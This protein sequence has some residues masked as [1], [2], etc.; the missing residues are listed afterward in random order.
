MDLLQR[1]IANN[2]KQ[3]LFAQQDR[4]VVAVS[5]GV[6]SVVLCELC[7]L[8]GLDFAMAHCNFQLRGEESQ[9]DETFVRGLEKRYQRTVW[10]K[11][12]DTEAYAT[13]NKLSIQEAARE[14]RYQ[15]FGELVHSTDLHTAFRHQQQGGGLHLLTAHHAGDNNETLLMHFFRGTGLH[16]LTGIPA[17]NGYVKRPLLGFTREEIREFA[18]EQ[19]LSWV[20][21][22][23]NAASDYTRNYFR[24]EL[25]PAISKVY[26]GVHQNLQDNIHR[27]SETEKLYRML[28]QGLLKKICVQK[29]N[30]MHVPVKALLKYD[31]RALIYELISPYGFHE[32]QVEEVLKLAGSESGKYILAPG[33]EW[34]IIKHRLWFIISPVLP[35]ASEA[36]IIEKDTNEVIFAGGALQLKEITDT[37]SISKDPHTALLDARHIEYPLLLRRWKTGDYFYPLGMRKKKK[38]GRFLIDL[39]LSKTEKENTWVIESKGRIIWVVGQRIDDR[40]KITDNTEQSVSIM[41]VC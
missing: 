9:R 28:V 12:F 22:S 40:C 27:F 13:A 34:R 18:N 11:Q 35:S 21:D 17:A 16:G 19:A 7:H 10:V 15:W 2:K 39:K 29:G 36:I 8:A 23:T 5:G 26:P 4:L 25:L 3:G 1:F 32:K 14:L 41:L 37:T 38:I 31:N 24:N 30:E 33:N 20:E 6:D